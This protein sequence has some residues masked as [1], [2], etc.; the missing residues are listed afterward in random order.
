MPN[1][2]DILDFEIENDLIDNVNFSLDEHFEE[3]LTEKSYLD[4]NHYSSL[5]S[6]ER[7]KMLTDYWNF[8]K[9]VFYGKV[10]ENLD[11][12][13]GFTFLKGLK[14][15]NGQ[16][17]YNPFDGKEINDIFCL[18]HKIPKK[19]KLN[20]DDI[21]IFS[22]EDSC[23]NCERFIKV[24]ERSIIKLEKI[25]NIQGVFDNL[26][27]DD[28]EVYKD[29]IEEINSKFLEENYYFKV[30][31]EKD[32]KKMA[33]DTIHKIQEEKQLLK[34][35]LE[36]LKDELIDE[37]LKFTKI[38]DDKL[39]ILK[40]IDGIKTQYEEIEK[41]REIYIK[42]G[43]LED[44]NKPNTKRQPGI[45][46][47]DKKV[48]HIYKYLRRREN[49]PLFYEK[50]IIEQFF[51]GLKTNQIIILGGSPGS[52]KTSLVQGVAEAI[53][54]NCKM[55]SV[56]PNWNG[57]E[58]LLG[59]YNPIDKC[60]VGTQMIDAIIDAANNP[61]EIYFI[62]LDEMNIAC[63]DEYFSELLSALYKDEKEL[64]LY[65]KDIYI[66]EKKVIDR[67]INVNGQT[68]EELISNIGIKEYCELER[69]AKNIN[70]YKPTIKIPD[71]IRFIGTINR[72]ATTKDLSPKVIDRSIIIN[73]NS[74]FDT[75]N[76][77]LLR[78]NEK[79]LQP[80]FIGSDEIKVIKGKEEDAFESFREIIEIFNKNDIELNFRFLTTAATML[81]I[82]NFSKRTLIDYI[83]AT[84]ILPKLNHELSDNGQLLLNK[85]SEF[86]A[87]G[88][89]S[90][91]IY[92]NM[93]KF[94]NEHEI[95]TYWR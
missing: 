95:L 44:D 43:W 62:C 61:E 40:E 56:R 15:I 73:I 86:V 69:R 64:S 22:I 14:N 21:I 54:A 89:I 9:N 63:V 46:G 23:R 41:Q 19:I 18:I 77:L 25:D 39:N 57:A 78:K 38:R 33:R 16:T 79:S 48:D 68:E 2:F 34:K 3:P 36:S 80:R 83:T 90:K 32:F 10:I 84:K 31:V 26:N 60:Y 30:Y 76:E 5:T 88:K 1:E 24:N 67:L 87:D 52:G 47:N 45:S 50:E 4:F 74:S 59:Y 17:V 35:D 94:Y 42:L 11:T 6:D 72:D 70:K 37:E 51:I 58:D 66:S 65:S 20:R 29:T 93:I 53:S 71:N 27:L 81:G 91:V 85:L 8:E 13:K 49:N 28:Y 7:I 12:E 75:F 92:E 82:E 55:V